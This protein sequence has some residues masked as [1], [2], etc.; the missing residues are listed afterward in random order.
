MVRSGAKEATHGSLR[1]T[2]SV[3][4]TGSRAV[5]GGSWRRGVSWLRRRRRGPRFSRLPT[6]RT[7][8]ETCLT[9]HED[10]AAS[11]KQGAHSRNVTG[12]GRR[13]RRRG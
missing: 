8:H 5:M 10:Q 6:R 7:R 9:C 11:V 1:K 13:W 4:A 3:R 12:R 2:L